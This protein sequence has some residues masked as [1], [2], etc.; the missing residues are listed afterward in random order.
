[1]EGVIQGHH[2]LAVEA[3]VEVVVLVGVAATA[4]LHHPRG[5][6]WLITPGVLA[7][8]E[9]QSV[10]RFL[11]QF[12]LGTEGA[13]HRM[14]IEAHHHVGEEMIEVHHQEGEETVFLLGKKVEG[15]IMAQTMVAAHLQG[16]GAQAPW[17]KLIRRGVPLGGRGMIAVAV[18]SRQ[19]AGLVI[20]VVGAAQVLP[21]LGELEMTR[22]T[23]VHLQEAVNRC[24]MVLQHPLE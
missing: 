18:P 19:M 14:K 9:V 10:L 11:H 6:E 21:L 16:A 1:M 17:M 2:H 15:L 12:L 8:V 4:G 24:L 23:A 3:E 5:N 22:M 7:E 20:M 13:A